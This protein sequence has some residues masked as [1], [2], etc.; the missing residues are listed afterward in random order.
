MK[1]LSLTALFAA[2]LVTNTAH[3]QFGGQQRS[4]AGQRIPTELIQGILQLLNDDH[5]TPT[6]NAVSL[7]GTWHENYNGTQIRHTIHAN[8]YHELYYPATGRT[9]GHMAHYDGRDLRLLNGLYTVTQLNPDTIQLGKSSET[10][11]WTR[12]GNNGNGGGI[13]PPLNQNTGVPQQLRGIWYAVSPEGTRW[14]YVIR[15][16][17]YDMF[18]FDPATNLPVMEDGFPVQLMDSSLTYTGGVLSLSPGTEFEDGPFMT[19][20]SPDSSQLFLTP[21]NGGPARLLTRNPQN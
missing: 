17:S 6:T 12:T 18:D 10:R 20:A 8:G 13:V 16:N 7:T 11:I 19:T 15:A 21:M 3:A 5:P 2:V 4:G 1:T 14:V 9:H